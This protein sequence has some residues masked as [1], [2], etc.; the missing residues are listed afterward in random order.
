MFRDTLRTRLPAG[1]PDWAAA[2]A[3]FSRSDTR[4]AVWQLVNTVLPYLALMTLAVVSRARDWPWPVTA[5]LVLPAAALQIRIFI[6][7]HD[8]CHDSFFA[9]RR[10]NRIT[11]Y[12]TGI[13]TFTPFDQWRRSHNLHHA[14]AGDLDSRGTGDIWTMTVDEYLAAPRRQR[15]GYRL[16]RNPFFLLLVVPFWLSVIAYRFPQRGAGA[17]AAASVLITDLAIAGVFALAAATVGWQTYVAVQLP[18][19]LIAWTMGVWLFYVQHQYED[20]YW[21]R[22]DEWTPIEAALRG[23]SYYKL[24]KVLQWFTG[25]IGLHHI[26][27]L[28][29]R[30]PNYHLQAC[31]DAVPALQKVRPLTLR[32]SLRS[33]AHNL[34]DEQK[35]QMVSFRAIRGRPRMRA[36]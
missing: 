32:R 35:Q 12:L 13:L 34:W 25:N 4:K 14:T 17:A 26:H 6:F 10:A 22:K 33:V 11:G 3:R 31:Q 15:L 29:P 20:A 24:P 23:S 9:S 36:W 1:R 30:I 16:V 5:A 28:R 21:V 18:V 2:V 19:I 27:H 8:C 7:F